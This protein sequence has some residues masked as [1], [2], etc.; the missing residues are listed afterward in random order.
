MDHVVVPDMV[1]SVYGTADSLRTGVR[2][3]TVQ[4]R[5]AFL[6][7]RTVSPGSRGQAGKESMRQHR[8]TSVI[9]H[10]VHLEICSRTRLR[11]SF[12]ISEYHSGGCERTACQLAAIRLRIR[13]FADLLCLWHATALSYHTRSAPTG[14]ALRDKARLRIRVNKYVIMRNHIHVLFGMYDISASGRLVAPTETGVV[15]ALS[16]TGMAVTATATGVVVTT[17]VSSVVSQK[18]ASMGSLCSTHMQ[19]LNGFQSGR[20]AR[21]PGGRETAIGIQERCE[22]LIRDNSSFRI[23]WDPHLGGLRQHQNLNRT[24]GI[25]SRLAIANARRAG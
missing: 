25:I 13:R 7:P 19:P 5:S 24:C 11:G 23:L 9:Q 14:I 18:S 2:R 21:A 16:D 22:L 20:D 15:V 1:E 6:T 10:M 8:K 17:T 3:A 4:I 12:G